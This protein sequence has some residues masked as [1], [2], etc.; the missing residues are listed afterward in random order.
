MK[1]K[2]YVAP[3]VVPKP[4]EAVTG[5]LIMSGLIVTVGGV[6]TIEKVSIAMGIAVAIIGLALMYIGTRRIPRP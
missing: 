1:T 4:N 6:G 3:C 5:L 2:S